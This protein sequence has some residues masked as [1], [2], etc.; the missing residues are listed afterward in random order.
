MAAKQSKTSADSKNNDPDTIKAGGDER[1]LNTRQDQP[2]L[3]DR[4]Y[5]PALIGLKI[6]INAPS[7]AISPVLD[8]ETEGTCTGLALAA[9]INLLRSRRSSA[10]NMAASNAVSPRMLYEM[11]KLHDQWPDEDY[12][13]SS[14]RGALK[15]FFHNGA[16][17]E[18]LA[19]YVDREKGWNLTVDQAKDARNTGLGAYYRLRPEIIDYHAALNEAG[20]I[21]VSANTHSGWTRPPSGVIT[22]KSTHQGGHAFIIV[23]YDEHGFIIQNSW[24]PRWGRFKG[25]PGVAHWSYADWAENIMDA[26]VIR[27]AVPTPKAFDLTHVPVRSDS[28]AAVRFADKPKPRRIDVLGHVIHLDDGD[29]VTSGRYGTSQANI[30]GTVDLLRADAAAPHPKYDHLAFYAHGGLNDSSAS[31]RRIKAM[32]EVFKRNRIY[33]VHFMWETGFTEELGDAFIAIFEKSRGRVGGFRDHLDWMIEKTARSVGRRLW[34]EMKLGAERA[35]ANNAGG[36]KAVSA[37]LKSNARSQRPLKL[38]LIGHSAG[39]ILHGHMLTRLD[40][41]AGTAQTVDSVSLMAPA[42][43]LEFYRQHYVPALSGAGRT[44]KTLQQYNLVDRRELDDTVGPYGKSLLY[45]ISNSFEAKR[46]TDLLGLETS[47]DEL[48]TPAAHTI[49]YAGRHRARTDSMKHGGFDNDRNTMNDV[50]AH[51]L[52]RKPSRADGFQ[53]EELIGY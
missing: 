9:A 19:P 27:L 14:I 11:A 5:E 35:F 34:N 39:S 46:G 20:V 37:F 33:P 13:G 32:K 41:L 47:L 49:Y 44:I 3:R 36:T 50:L 53:D 16:C 7:P 51:I 29:L 52:G 22:K 31:A 24:G 45:F 12:D 25:S 6:A 42:C 10:Q 23:G 38:H 18:Q 28:A 26:W 1:I 4:M 30:D 21:Y 8:Q 15:G 48:Q 40:T 2:D 43:T 17:S